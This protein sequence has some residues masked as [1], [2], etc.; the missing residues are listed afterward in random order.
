MDGQAQ[1]LPRL[2]LFSWE[3]SLVG[4]NEGDVTYLQGQEDGR[5]TASELH[6]Y[7][8]RSSGGATRSTGRA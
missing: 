4:L 5:A 7:V 1:Q 8:G 3:N 6:V 2:G